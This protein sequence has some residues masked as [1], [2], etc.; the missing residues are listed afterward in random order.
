[1]VR[2]YWSSWRYIQSYEMPEMTDLSFI[3]GKAVFF[4][5]LFLFL[6]LKMTVKFVPVSS[7]KY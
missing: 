6:G 4:Y 2:T 1:M 5:F 7:I 3:R